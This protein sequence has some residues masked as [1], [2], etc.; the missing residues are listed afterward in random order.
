IRAAEALRGDG[1]HIPIVAMTANAMAGDRELCLE[2]GMDGY[3]SKPIRR[4]EFFTAIADV[5]PPERRLQAAAPPLQANLFADLADL[6][7]APAAL[8]DRAAALARLDGDEELFATLVQ[9][10]ADELPAYCQRLGDTLAAGDL[11]ALA[12]EAH[13]LKGLL[14]TFSAAHGT[15]LA[16]DL[17]ARAKAGKGEGAAELV[18]QLQAEME[19]VRQELQSSAP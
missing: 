5:L 19:K 16:Q 6:V 17:E 8:C 18:R 15:A 14:G 10:Y 2:A 3:V 12:R 13:T 1:S 11:P 7:A 9:L 4:D